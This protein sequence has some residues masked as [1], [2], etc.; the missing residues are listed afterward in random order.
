MIWNWSTSHNLDNHKS[1]YKLQHWKCTRGKV[2]GPAEHTTNTYNFVAGDGYAIYILHI[3]I[4]YILQCRLIT[5]NMWFFCHLKH[6]FKKLEK[7]FFKEKFVLFNPM[8]ASLWS[9]LISDPWLKVFEIFKRETIN[10]CSGRE[11]SLS[12]LGSSCS[13]TWNWKTGHLGHRW[14]WLFISGE[15][16]DL[17]YRNTHHED[18]EIISPGRRSVGRKWKF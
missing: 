9:P 17:K 5:M 12:L 11:P 8:I 13:A 6:R 18:Q 10:K 7:F 2:W 14:N 4:V 16:N 3:Y 15:R 1:N